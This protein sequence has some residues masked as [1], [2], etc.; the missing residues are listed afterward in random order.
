MITKSQRLFLRT[1]AQT[2]KSKFQI[3]K[4]QLTAESIDNLSRG[5][6]GAELIKVT[7]L[8]AAQPEQDSLILDIASKLK[9]DIVQVIGHQLVLYRANP[10]SRKIAFPS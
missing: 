10:K 4:H 1:K 9:A 8:K 5:L 7:L 3:G 6:D 2:L